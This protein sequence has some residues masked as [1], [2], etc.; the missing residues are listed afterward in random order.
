[1]SQS[2]K[3]LG[4]RLEGGFPD[5]SQDFS[6]ALEMES[7]HIAVYLFCM[8]TSISEKVLK[9]QFRDAAAGTTSKGP[10]TQLFLGCSNVFTF[11]PTFSPP[12]S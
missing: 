4:P 7:T 12:L 8:V 1:M 3:W 11:D 9:P 5:V 10:Y 6:R 2:A